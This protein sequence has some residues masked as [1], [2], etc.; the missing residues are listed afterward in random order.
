M[1]DRP[2]EVADGDAKGRAALDRLG[3]EYTRD[4]KTGDPIFSDEQK[5]ANRA[6]LKKPATGGDADPGPT[7]S[8]FP[9]GRP[10]VSVG[11]LP[12]AAP[13]SAEDARA[14]SRKASKERRKK[15]DRT[16][17]AAKESAKKSL[18]KAGFKPGTYKG[19]RAEGGLMN[20]KGNK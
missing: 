11:S 16:S 19:G 4:E 5:I 17:K 2:G 6:K 15:K 7:S 18:K 10:S 20:K 13:K 9:T 12:A 1:C 3:L 14:E 8:S